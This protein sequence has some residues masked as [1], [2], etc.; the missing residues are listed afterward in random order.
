MDFDILVVF[1]H[2]SK[3]MCNNPVGLNPRENGLRS[4]IHLRKVEK[5]LTFKA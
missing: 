4:D 5:I 2:A 1:F 3:H